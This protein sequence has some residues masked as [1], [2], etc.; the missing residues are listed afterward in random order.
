MNLY[1]FQTLENNNNISEVI[2]GLYG[3]KDSTMSMCN[4][5]PILSSF[6]IPIIIPNRL[7]SFLCMHAYRKYT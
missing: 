2:F 1:S 5:I 4:A 3:V 7:P 6:A